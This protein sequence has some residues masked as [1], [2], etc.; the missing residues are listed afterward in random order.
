MG[1]YRGPKISLRSV[2]RAPV[3]PS[4][5][6]VVQRRDPAALQGPTVEA[7]ERSRSPEGSQAGPKRAPKRARSDAKGHQEV[8]KYRPER[9]RQR[10]LAGND[11]REQHE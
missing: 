1:V 4:A 2:W 9:H 5:R 7:L 8:A 11:A 10:K 6:Q 3:R